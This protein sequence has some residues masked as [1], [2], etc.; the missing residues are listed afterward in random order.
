[1]GIFEE[2]SGTLLDSSGIDKFNRAGLSE[3]L[4]LLILSLLSPKQ[5][6]REMG[7]RPTQRLNKKFVNALPPKD[8]DYEVTDSEIS[9]FRVRVYT[10]GTKKWKIYYPRPDDKR[11]RRPYTIG[12]AGKD[13]ISPDTA[14]GIAKAKLAEV[15]KDIDPLEQAKRKQEEHT[16]RT[17]LDT[18]Y[19][20]YVLDKRVSGDEAM[21][22]IRAEFS[23]LYDMK[24]GEI[25][26]LDLERWRRRRKKDNSGN[27]VDAVTINRYLAEL[28][29]ALGKAIEWFPTQISKNPCSAVKRDYV[30]N[31]RVRY[32]SAVEEA[33][34]RT[35]L[36]ER[37]ERLCAERDEENARRMKHGLP[38]LPNLRAS[39]FADELKPA[40]LI[41]LGTGIRRRELFALK[42]EN[43]ILDG[44]KPRLALKKTKSKKPRDVDLNS[45]L[46]PVLKGWPEQSKG[47]ACV[48]P[49][50]G[51][52]ERREMLTI[53]W[54]NVRRAEGLPLKGPNHFTWRDMRHHF[55]SILMQAGVPLLEVM[56]L[57]GDSKYET[58]LR[59]AH[60]AAEN[61]A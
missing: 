59:Y 45:E 34:L 8:V 46:V 47:D 61:T 38:R 53:Q 16:L 29:A 17:F 7:K 41:F 42:W 51:G 15:A 11:K 14:R 26:S 31:T 2:L 1:M 28:S 36:D 10:S 33:S 6:E 18:V 5:E 12:L 48:F 60:L 3:D 52:A 54:R 25:H 9:G 55:S 40:V 43:V 49:G 30:D 57:A 23:D 58:T 50:K 39:A 37:E 24:L 4:A 56:R 22:N 32:L 44:D 19:E 35:A 13:G 21:R 27:G 20:P